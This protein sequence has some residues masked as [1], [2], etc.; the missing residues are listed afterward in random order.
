MRRNSGTERAEHD[1]GDERLH[2]EQSPCLR[3][4][5]RLH[6]R[7]A[8]DVRDAA[9]SP[10]IAPVPGEEPARA[11]KW[12]IAA[13]PCPRAPPRQ[14]GMSPSSSSQLSGSGRAAVM[15]ANWT[16]TPEATV[17]QYLDYL[18]AGKWRGDS[19]ALNPAW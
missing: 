19:N 6:A 5:P 16:R 8:A 3:Y 13:T 17:R 11:D 18:A 2:P 12:T 9:S 1:P 10:V 7:C 15:F 4:P 14:A